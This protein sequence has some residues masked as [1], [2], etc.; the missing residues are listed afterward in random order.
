MI[1]LVLECIDIH[2]AVIDVH[3]FYTYTLIV[4]L[5]DIYTYTLLSHESTFV[6]DFI[7]CQYYFIL[8]VYIFDSLTRG[9]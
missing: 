1:L 7:S 3:A 8:V 6:Y 4:V 5:C 9:R 2:V